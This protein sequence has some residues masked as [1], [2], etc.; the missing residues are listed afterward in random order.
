M[1]KIKKQSKMGEFQRFLP[2]NGMVMTQGHF[3]RQTCYFPH[4]IYSPC[5]FKVL[6]HL[7]DYFTKYASSFDLRLILGP[8]VRKGRKYLPYIL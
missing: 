4:W 1:K 3:I 6:S 7:H 8:K 5:A 2:N